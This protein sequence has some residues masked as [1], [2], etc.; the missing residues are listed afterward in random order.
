MC[1]RISGRVQRQNNSGAFLK[2]QRHKNIGHKDTNLCLFNPIFNPIICI[3]VI[4]TQ[5]CRMSPPRSAN[6][7][8]D[9]SLTYF[10]LPPQRA[11]PCHGEEPHAAAARRR[12]CLCRTLPL[13]A[14]ATAAAAAH[15]C[16][17]PYSAA[18][19]ATA[20]AFADDNGETASATSP[21]WA[22]P[23]M[24]YTTASDTPLIE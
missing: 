20:D 10:H 7:C 18:T 3:P 1:R 11:V 12:L 2:T 22:P 19:V 24:A 14:A 21:P 9:I 17:M 23:V 4:K 13:P 6:L 15:N 5:I 16:R 8:P